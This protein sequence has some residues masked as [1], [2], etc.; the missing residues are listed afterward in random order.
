MEQELV[1]IIMS[2]YNEKEPWIRKA[3]ESVIKQTYKFIEFIIV[4]DN[5][6]N[7]VIRNIVYDYSKIDNRIVVIE[8]ENNLGLVGSLNEAL[9]ISKGIYIAR[10]DADDISKN[11]RIEKQIDFLRRTKC[12]LVGAGVAFIDEFDKLM[13]GSDE[14]F[15]CT[16][17][18]I[19]HTLSFQNCI[20]HPTW[21]V[22]KEL[23]LKLNGYRNISCC[24]DYDFLLRAKLLKAKLAVF[25][26]TLVYY[27]YNT[28]GISRTNRA[29]QRC[30]TL[31]MRSKRNI[32]DEISPDN[33]NEFPCTKKGK[34][35]MDDC[36][37]Y[38]TY[39]QL[40]IESKANGK[41]LYQLFAMCKCVL[42]TYNGKIKVIDVLRNQY[43]L[44]QEE[45][46]KK[47]K[48]ETIY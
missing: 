31:Y 47:I 10:M 1:S 40:A 36:E 21:L 2:T 13:F 27:R 32:L 38:Y 34:R 7:I 24:E 9:R 17:Y 25:P 5:P 23:Y 6:D 18:Y 41:R 30:I 16:D 26:E 33:I 45:F 29:K 22:R 14:K 20:Y 11:E 35:I 4:L 46:I 43:L 44:F 8:N 15:H 12:D 28:R 3:I 48:I 42:K 19:K 37:K 39:S